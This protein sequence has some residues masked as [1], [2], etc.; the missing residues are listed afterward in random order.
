MHTK[1]TPVS[2]TKYS[3]TLRPY[4]IDGVAEARKSLHEGPTLLVSPTGAG[5]TDMA[6]AIAED[7]RNVLFVAHRRELLAQAEDPMGSHVVRMSIQSALRYGPE[8]VQLLIIDEAHRAKAK[9]YRALIEKYSTAAR[10][11]LTATPLRT[12]GQGLCDAFSHMVQVSSVKELVETGWLVP[13]LDPYGPSAEAL[14]HL[15]RLKKMKKSGADYDPTALAELV[16][17]PRLVGRVADEYWNNA[18]GRRAIV[19]AVNIEHSK[20]L[21]AAFSKLGIRAAH[22]DGRASV[23]ER[24]A[25]LARVASGE[26]DVLCNVNLFTEGWNCR[27]I[28]CVIMARPTL[29]LT[30]YLQS[31]GRGMR[32][33][34]A[35]GKQ[36]LL[37]IDHAGNMARHGMPDEE[38]EWSLESRAQREKREK[39]E[40]DEKEWRDAGYESLEQY[41]L[42]VARLI[43]DTYTAT[44][45]AAI[46]R[47]AG[48]SNAGSRGMPWGRNRLPSACGLGVATRYWK[49]DVDEIASIWTNSYSRKECGALLNIKG[50]SSAMGKS[51]RLIKV[52]PIFGKFNNLRYSRAQI[53]ALRNKA[54]PLTSCESCQREFATPIGLG[55]HKFRVH[56]TTAHRFAQAEAR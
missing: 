35:S 29:S 2:T 6:A 31:V 14:A 50:D 36:N 15:A 46:F 27:A 43:Q 17:T 49:K 16:N 37:I 52:F 55:V 23:K 30:L 5:K 56:P 38:R 33:D 41:R 4:Q 20:A 47:S 40:A 18:R 19:F 8:K 54:L 21:E 26:V 7:Y 3:G 48:V 13:Y 42:E 44:Q 34:P 24:D 1:G 22:I 25:A 11:G 39:E 12:D 53:D 28:S 51:L 10:L 9:T 32:P 45:A